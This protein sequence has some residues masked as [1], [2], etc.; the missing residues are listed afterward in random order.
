MRETDCLLKKW[1]ESCRSPIPK[2]SSRHPRD[3][4]AEKRN[5]SDASSKHTFHFLNSIPRRH[6]HPQNSPPLPYSLLFVQLWASHGAQST[7]TD[8]FFA[9]RGRALR[10]SRCVLYTCA[11]EPLRPTLLSTVHTHLACAWPILY[12]HKR[13]DAR[14]LAALFLNLLRNH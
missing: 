3:F 1:L 5:S 7:G 10:K 12:V 14:N 6:L 2:A 4:R 8:R 13:V 9:Q 11:L